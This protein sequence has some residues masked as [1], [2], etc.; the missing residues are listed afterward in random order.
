MYSQ[1]CVRLAWLHCASC[2]CSLWPG[3]LWWHGGG[4]RGCFSRDIARSF[5]TVTSVMLEHAQCVMHVHSIR[6]LNRGGDGIASKGSAVCHGGVWHRHNLPVVASG[7]VHSAMHVVFLLHTQP[8]G[9]LKLHSAGL[10][11]MMLMA[12]YHILW[13]IAAVACCHQI[14]GFARV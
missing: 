6:P 7:C 4:V 12:L 5:G 10:G 3:R 11:S 8:L 13:G 14:S 1:A 9:G 2:C